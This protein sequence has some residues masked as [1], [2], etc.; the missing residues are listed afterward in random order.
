MV[1]YIR[2]SLDKDDKAAF[3]ADQRTLRLQWTGSTFTRMDGITNPG[4]GKAGFA[5]LLPGLD[6]VTW[7][8]H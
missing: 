4:L 6:N 3:I 8:T 5:L 1:Y 7:I 2:H